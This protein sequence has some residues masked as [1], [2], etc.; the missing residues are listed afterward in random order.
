LPT[1]KVV[2]VRVR[3]QGDH[4]EQ[5]AVYADMVPP[6]GMTNPNGC[7]PVGRVINSVVTLGPGAAT[8]VSLNLAFDC[9]NRAGALNESYTIMAAADPHADDGGA[10]PVFQIQSMTCYMALADDDNDPGD[11]RATTNSFRVK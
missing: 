7:T 9:S 11:N 1:T 3:N 2:S 4:A 6:G 5:I 8:T 10:C